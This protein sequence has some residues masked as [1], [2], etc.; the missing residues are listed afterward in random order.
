MRKYEIMFIV[1]PDLEE[2]SIAEIVK[3]FENIL[4]NNKAKVEKVDSLGKKDLA[5]EIKKHKSGYY[6][7]ITFET[8]TDAPIK[9]FNRVALISEDMIRHL[10][11]RLDK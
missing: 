3:N 6:Y 8:E 2:G 10:V 7:L 5:Y 9:E 11:V 4:V 1:R